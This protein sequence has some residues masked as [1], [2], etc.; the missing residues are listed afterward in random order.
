MEYC[1]VRSVT[2]LKKA[3]HSL[4]NSILWLIITG[5]VLI[6]RKD[7]KK[8]FSVQAPDNRKYVFSHHFML[9]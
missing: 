8:G 3:K 6:M 2:N 1:K 4:S 9:V 5:N 7:L